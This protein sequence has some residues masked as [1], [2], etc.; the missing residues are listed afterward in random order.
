MYR[1]GDRSDAAE[2]NRAS[3]KIS[4]NAIRGD[5]ITTRIPIMTPGSRG[6]SGMQPSG[7]GERK[8]AGSIAA[9]APRSEPSRACCFSNGLFCLVERLVEYGLDVGLVRQTLLTC[10]PAC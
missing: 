6:R 1:R 3:N 4:T 9:N 7:D 5:P 8:W 10:L 2:F